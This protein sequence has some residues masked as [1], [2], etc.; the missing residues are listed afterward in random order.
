MFF[1]RCLFH[2]RG[3]SPVQRE[4]VYLSY[5]CTSCESKASPLLDIK[6]TPALERNGISQPLSNLTC[7]LASTTWRRKRF[8]VVCIPLFLS[9]DEALT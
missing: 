5:G 4:Q 8:S 3:P 2:H 1:F 7:P 6:F 9:F